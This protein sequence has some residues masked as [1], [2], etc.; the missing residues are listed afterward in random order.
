MEQSKLYLKIVNDGEIDINAF[1]LLGVTTKDETKI[2]YFGSGLKY[3]LAVLL[4]EKID[5]KIYSGVSEIKMSTKETTFRGKKCEIIKINNGLTSLTT[6]MGRDWKIWYA[7]R[8][9]YCNAIDEGGQKITVTDKFEP[10][11]GST[12]F[13]VEFNDSVRDIS[14]NWNTYF[15]DKR[16]D[17]VQDIGDLKIYN[18]EINKNLESS[19][20][21]KKSIIIYRKGIQVYNNEKIKSLFDYDSTSI[22]INEARELSDLWSFKYSLVKKL[23]NSANLEIIEDICD[24]WRDTFEGDLMW[25]YSYSFHDN[26]LDALNGRTIIMHDV[27]G[28]YF[29]E[30]GS[31]TVILPTKLAKSLSDYFGDKVNVR[32]Y[33]KEYGD[34]DVSNPSDKQQNIINE[35]VE[36]LK[37]GNLD[38][39]KLVSSIKICNFRSKNIL[40]EAINGKIILIS[41]NCFEHGKRTVLATIL[42]EYGHIS[43]EACDKTRRFQDFLINLYIVQLED[44]LNQYF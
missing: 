23:S 25:E 38:I 18:H 43:S 28:N 7:I 10:E 1:K 26:W 16:K 27:S 20:D 44:K 33:S 42:E 36:F 13:Y 21:K 34:N 32:G 22:D 17:L 4:R 14:K 8:E 24:N 19:L 29:E 30:L 2:G 40:G 37:R 3:A 5:F 35:C 31:S 15:S 6:D 41:P 12:Q 39:L 11:K 9:L